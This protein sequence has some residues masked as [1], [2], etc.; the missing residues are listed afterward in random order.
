M[1]DKWVKEERKG[2]KRTFLEKKIKAQHRYRHN[3]KENNRPISL[4]D[5]GSKFSN[6]IV[7]C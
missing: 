7:V 1:D 2:N 4:M 3:K 5:I 6:K